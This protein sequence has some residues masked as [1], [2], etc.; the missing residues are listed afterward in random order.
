MQ[1][2]EPGAN[3]VSVRRMLQP[4]QTRLVGGGGAFGAGG[5][6][7]AL[8]LRGAGRVGGAFS[9]EETRPDEP[10]ALRRGVGG[11]SG[12]G[13]A[14]TGNGGEASDRPTASKVSDTSSGTDSYQFP[15]SRW[16]GI[17]PS[18]RT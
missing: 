15:V 7:G 13:W 10:A 8:T 6:F 16:P 18:V 9:A 11:G 12:V 17:R 14:G 5:G 4:G 1:S 2:S 3:C